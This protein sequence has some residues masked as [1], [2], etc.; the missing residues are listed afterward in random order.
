MKMIAL[1]QVLD[2][3]RKLA[4]DFQSCASCLECTERYEQAVAHEQV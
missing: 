4:Y 1:E 2:K 3:W